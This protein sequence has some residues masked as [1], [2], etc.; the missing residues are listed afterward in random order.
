MAAVVN[1]VGVIYFFKPV[2]ERDT[3]NLS[4]PPMLGFLIFV[5]LSI[6]LFDWAVRQSGSTYKPAVIIGASQI[7]L[8]LDQMLSGKRGVATALAGAAL[9]VV[10]WACVAGVYSALGRR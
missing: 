8:I 10:T 5:L 2:T 6:A 4:V 3:S 7:I 9:V 1:L